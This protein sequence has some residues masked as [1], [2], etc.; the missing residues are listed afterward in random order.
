[1]TRDNETPIHA[2]TYTH[3]HTNARN[4]EIAKLDA[5]GA[6]YPAL[7]RLDLA[8]DKSWAISFPVKKSSSFL[9]NLDT[10]VSL[11]FLY[12]PNQTSYI[13]AQKSK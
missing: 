7:F 5:S 4:T 2:Q 8:S 6:V 13:S 9:K 10:K 1:M 11:F 3:T 12:L